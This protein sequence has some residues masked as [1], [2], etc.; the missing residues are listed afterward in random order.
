MANVSIK[1]KTI[2]HFLLS[3]L[4]VLYWLVSTD[5]SNYSWNPKGEELDLIDTATWKIFLF[6]CTFW[7]I[8]TNILIYSLF[9][10]IRKSLAKV[11]FSFFI[12]AISL[13]FIKPFINRECADYYFTI[14][15]NQSVSEEYIDDVIYEAG[16]YIG[17]KINNELLNSDFKYRDYAIGTLADIEYY[18]SIEN[19]IRLL[20]KEETPQHTKDRIVTELIEF[21]T[22]QSL[23]AVEEYN[24]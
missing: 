24:S 19:L 8:L 6:K 17:L 10:L 9:E 22:D 20:N 15:K 4:V 14:F 11:L 23:N 21:G 7:L 13:I 18:P 1:Y 3:L 5:S 12:F 16:Y 2:V